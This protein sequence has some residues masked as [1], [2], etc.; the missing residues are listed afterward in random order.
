MYSKFLITAF[1]FFLF[2]IPN[3]LRAQIPTLPEDITSIK[4][5]VKKEDFES[6][7][8]YLKA[9]DFTI[10]KSSFNCFCILV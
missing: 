4:E 1:V 3:K 6:L 7:S 8:K 9:N 2:A 10:L 5:L